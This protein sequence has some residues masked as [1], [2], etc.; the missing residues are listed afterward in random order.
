M[1]QWRRELRALGAEAPPEI[2]KKLSFFVVFW[3]ISNFLRLRRLS[4]PQEIFS[5]KFCYF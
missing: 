5:Y 3:E 2:L 1:G 4:E